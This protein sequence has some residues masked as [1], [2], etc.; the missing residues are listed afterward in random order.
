MSSRR[1][2]PDTPRSCFAC[3][4]Y[5]DVGFPFVVF[6][7]PA[8]GGVSPDSEVAVSYLAASSRHLGVTTAANVTTG[9]HAA[10]T[11]AFLDLFLA[12]ATPSDVGN[13][14]SAVMWGERRRSHI[15]SHVGPVFQTAVRRLA[16][17]APDPGVAWTLVDSGTAPSPRWPFC[18]GGKN[19]SFAGIFLQ[20]RFIL[21]R[22]RRS[23]IDLFKIP[24]VESG[25]GQTTGHKWVVSC[26]SPA[27][28]G[29]Q[30]DPVPGRGGFIGAG[31]GH[32]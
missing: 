6:S 7:S 28:S 18:V 22:Y 31:F 25:C 21:P 11:R 4:P 19:I 29:L 3:H 5:G 14:C 32:H 16:N 20:R 13:S 30:E 8:T 27:W 10:H 23:R 15:E 24:L 2:R 9:P 12:T 26:T 1:K 17:F